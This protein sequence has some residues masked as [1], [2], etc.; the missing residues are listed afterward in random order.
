MNNTTTTVAARY[1][2][3]D[4]SAQSQ[5]ARRLVVPGLAAGAV[6]LGFEMLAGAFS[7]SAWAFPQSIPQTVGLTL[8]T[9]ALDPLGLVVS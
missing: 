6:F 2:S 9:A 8:P 3:V 7:T 5:T 4:I 1:P